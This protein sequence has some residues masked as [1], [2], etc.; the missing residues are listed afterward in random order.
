MVERVLDQEVGKLGAS[1][2]GFLSVSPRK[3]HCA[4][5]TISFIYKM[6]G[7]HNL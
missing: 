4:T 7:E 5:P 1:L 3:S 6:R 2:H